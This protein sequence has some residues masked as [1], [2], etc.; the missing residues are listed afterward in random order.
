M[1]NVVSLNIS[2]PIAS[3]LVVAGSLLRHSGSRVSIPVHCTKSVSGICSLLLPNLAVII[4]VNVPFGVPLK[5]PPPQEQ[6]NISISNRWESGYRRAKCFE[7]TPAGRTI[8]PIMTKANSQGA[9]RKGVR[10]SAPKL[11]A[12]LVTLTVKAVGWVAPITAVAGRLQV[13]PLGAPVQL[14]VA[15]PLIPAPP[16]E[17][18]YLAVFPPASLAESE[19]PG[20]MLNPKPLEMPVPVSETVCG[21][22][23]ALSVTVRL[24]FSV[25]VRKGLKVNWTWH[26]PNAGNS[27]PQLLV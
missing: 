16:M 21:L 18:E 10:R 17:S 7:L 26:V 11:G 19:P 25:P 24:P 5:S 6:R 14:S 4:R 1:T 8:H 22:W 13:V 20:A 3:F 15:V 9:G 2:S 27:E 12:W 23:G